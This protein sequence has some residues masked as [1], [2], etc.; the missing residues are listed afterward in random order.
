MVN[1]LHIVPTRLSGPSPPLTV[2]S[3]PSATESILVYGIFLFAT[4]VYSDTTHVLSVK[5]PTLEDIVSKQRLTRLFE[6]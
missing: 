6:S 4:L 5:F 2:Q 3:A 1:T